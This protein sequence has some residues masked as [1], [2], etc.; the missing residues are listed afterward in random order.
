METFVIYWT[1][2]EAGSRITCMKT[3]RKETK[4]RE[5]F[6]YFP[7]GT[8][9]P[10]LIPVTISS[11]DSLLTF[12]YIT[13]GCESVETVCVNQDPPIRMIVDENGLFN[14]RLKPNLIGCTLY[15]GLIVG[16]IIL[17][18]EG[19]RDGEPDI[20]GFDTMMQAQEV[21]QKAV[22][23][24]KDHFRNTLVQLYGT[25]AKTLHPEFFD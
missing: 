17:A 5:W 3:G 18:T 6:V 8:L 23:A 20:V 21:A 24:A 12:L 19:Q 15:N 4:M 7:V 25:E 11:E 9:K 14:E 13:I 22:K 10:Q 1:C 16:G 2:T